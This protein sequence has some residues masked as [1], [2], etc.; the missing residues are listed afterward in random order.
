MALLTSNLQELCVPVEDVWGCPRLRAASTRCILLPKVSKGQWS[1]AF[2]VLWEQFAII[3][4]GIAVCHW[5][6]LGRGYRRISLVVH[7]NKHYPTLL[8]H[9][10]IVA[11]SIDVQTYSCAHLEHGL[12][13]N[14]PL[15]TSEV[16]LRRSSQ[17]ISWLVQN[18][19]PSQPITGLILTNWTIEYHQIRK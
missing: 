11:A 5:W 14:V 10:V 19:Q 4:L 1:L 16:T 2:Q 17:P 8:G 12:N 6:R 9:F 15:N 7:N 13:F 3:S 18:T